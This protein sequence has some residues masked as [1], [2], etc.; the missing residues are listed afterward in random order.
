M[1]LAKLQDTKVIHRNLL[2]LYTNNELSESN[3]KKQPNLHLHQKNKIHQNKSNRR[4]KD[5]ENYKIL[6]KK[7]KMIQMERCIVLMHWKN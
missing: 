3:I 1:N 7:L 4:V 2:F 5:S 6:M